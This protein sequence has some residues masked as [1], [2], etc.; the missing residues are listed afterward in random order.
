MKYDRLLSPI[1]IGR[2]EL[3]NRVIMPAMD[4]LLTENGYASDRYNKF[5]WARAEGGAALITAGGAVIDDYGSSYDMM[6]LDED[7]YIEGYKK[8][9]DGIHE[10][11]AKTMVQ[12][13]HAG[14]YAA[15]LYNQGRQ[16]IAPS[17]VYSGYS[18]AMPKEMTADEIHTVEDK[19][20]EAAVRAQQAGF[21]IIEIIA[22]AGYLICQFLSPFTNHRNDEYGGSWENRIRF[23]QET[24]T[25]VRAAVGPDQPLSMRIAGHDLVPGS[26]TDQDAVK[27]AKAMEEAGIDMLNVTGGWH[28]SKVPQITG[29]LP[30]GG[31]DFIAAEIRDAVNIP[32]AV[33]NRI[34]DPAAAERILALGEADLVSLGRPHIA[35]PDW[36]KKTEAGRPD[37]IRHCL[38]CNQGCLAKV[39]FNE[40]IQCLVNPE[41][42][43]ECET[44]PW[45]QA[46][47][48][49]EQKHILVIG[50][51]PAGLEFAMRAGACGHRVTIWE[52]SD[53]IG[54]QLLLAAAPPDKDEFKTLVEYYRGQLEKYG[55]EIVLNR[56]ADGETAAKACREE[57][58]DFVVT[59]VGRGKTKNIPLEIHENIPVYTA[60]DVLSK[61]V[62]AGRAPLII[63]GG[64]VGCE[65]AHYLAEEGALTPGQ[66][67][68]M[69]K[70]GYETP[71]RVKELM[72]QTRRSV[73]IV[74]VR[75]IGGGFEPGT[76]WP[77]MLDLKRF[78]VRKFRFSSVAKIEDGTAT[79][80][81]REEEGGPVVKT[82]EIPVTD[83]IFATGAEQN[84]QISVDL[85]QAGV[86]VYNIGDSGRL[87]NALAA[88]RQAYDLALALL[89][90]K[91]EI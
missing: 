89:A 5:L 27:F 20:A 71:D 11:G 26:N 85:R 24:V 64:T 45:I 57:D 77:L 80:E 14:R 69:M 33:G 88:I 29:A 17:P 91:T 61:R 3:K 42:G 56:H 58:W 51:G 36:V 76:S 55:V 65:T 52:A 10:R 68:H 38:G 82:Q 43:R 83:V 9:T 81:I 66:V 87:G 32:V 19:F 30:R 78:G 21:D 7:K 70:Y 18:K 2:V 1:K 90:E 41:A 79:L 59:C 4:T 37:L 35:D 74:D 25:K 73:S 75:K 28:E 50:A 23:A 12:L 8:M 84:D 60:A 47:T 44:R 63:G 46:R 62:E 53:H 22:S 72:D 39:F 40:P 48:A 86:E 54:G 34:S 6:H 16:P 67:Y 15:P 31:F 13:F 49:A